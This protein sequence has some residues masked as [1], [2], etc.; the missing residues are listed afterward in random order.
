RFQS[1]RDLAFNL[2]LLSAETSS[3]G[4]IAPAASPIGSG[5]AIRLLLGSLA[6]LA[7]A[8]LGFFAAHW[9]VPAGRESPAVVLRRLTDFE[10]MEEFPS[11]SP[12]GNSVAFTAN[13]DGRRQIWVRLLAGGTALQVT[14]DNTDH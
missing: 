9:Q 12:D 1:A 4:V 14:R 13:V 3:S 7:A 8:S 5:R 10:G 11:L 2:E 6:L